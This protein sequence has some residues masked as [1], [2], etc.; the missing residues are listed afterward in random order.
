MDCHCSLQ[1]EF[2]VSHLALISL[3]HSR[4]T[5]NNNNQNDIIN[6][7]Y[8]FGQMALRMSVVVVGIVC[9]YWLYDQVF[10]EYAIDNDN[11]DTYRVV[12]FCGFSIIECHYD[13]I[14]VINLSVIVN[15]QFWSIKVV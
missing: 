5:S 10:Y 3:F 11:I 9:L 14:C 7:F 8:G 6:F 1:L 2:V 12:L 15:A 13:Y 4:G